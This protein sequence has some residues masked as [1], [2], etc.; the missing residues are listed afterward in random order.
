MQGAAYSA[1]PYN[2]RTP[3]PAHYYPPQT[4]PN[5]Y[6]NGGS[7]EPT[8]IYAD[9][10]QMP[11]P[12]NA[13]Q[14]SMPRP[15]EERAQ[16][17][18][19]G[20]GNT[21]MPRPKQLAS[22]YRPQLKSAMKRPAR[23]VSDPSDQLQRA[24]TNSDPRRTLNPMTRTRTSS[25]VAKDIPD[26][27]FVSLHGGSYLQIQNVNLHLVNELRQ[28]L[29]M[30]WPHGVESESTGKD[31]TWRVN[32]AKNPWSST[33]QDAIMVLRMIIQLFT[34]I[35]LGHDFINTI[36]ILQTPPRLVFAETNDPGVY[37]NHFVAYFSRSGRKLTLV[38]PPQIL[39][40]VIGSRLRAAWPHKIS[41][42]R[43]P[44]DGIY[45]VGLRATTFGSYT[46]DKH[47][48]MSYALQ[49]IRSL[50]YQFVASVP[51][52]RRGPLGLGSRREVLVF[53]DMMSKSAQR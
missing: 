14:N 40:E 9:W 29:L 21:P 45:T 10:P 37:I 51:L 11:Q 24:R 38:D 4:F 25:N 50:G 6:P 2:T 43:T 5:V 28:S 18:S 39:G 30:M 7:R 27:L 22:R 20:P 13:A 34:R 47:L 16:R 33:G 53:K 15:R 41:A 52:G 17:Q 12:P 46:L 31:N 23:S 42:D 49:E 1:Y 3:Y 36:N 32:F 8:T 19:N 48:F 44:E 35:T 26:H